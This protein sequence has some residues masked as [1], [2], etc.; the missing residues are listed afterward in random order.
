[1]TCKKKQIKLDDS[2]ISKSISSIICFPCKHFKW[3]S[4]GNPFICEA[5]PKGIPD[6]IWS[7]KNDHKK[8]YSGDHGIQFEPK[9]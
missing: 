4:P 1:M 2:Q 6:E 5:F 3:T 9:E 8:P 7:G